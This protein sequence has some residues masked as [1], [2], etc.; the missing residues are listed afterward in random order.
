[1]IG[2]FSRAVIAFLKK[3]DGPTA[4]EYAVVLALIIAVVISVSNIG[5]TTNAAYS[6][7]TLQNATGPSGS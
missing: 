2:R 3:E 4:V 5:N 6:N 7:S 1:M